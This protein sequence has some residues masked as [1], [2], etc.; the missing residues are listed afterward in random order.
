[1]QPIHSAQA[2]PAKREITQR[3]TPG[4][5]TEPMLQPNGPRRCRC[6]LA[7]LK[8]RRLVAEKLRIPGVLHNARLDAYA[9]V[10]SSLMLFTLGSTTPLFRLT[11]RLRKQASPKG[12]PIPAHY[13]DVQTRLAAFRP[14]CETNILVGASRVA[15][16]EAGEASLASCPIDSGCGA[17]MVLAMHSFFGDAVRMGEEDAGWGGRGGN[18]R[19]KIYALERHKYIRRGHTSRRV[20][21][22]STGCGRRDVSRGDPP[23]PSIL[24]VPPPVRAPVGS[25]ILVTRT[26]ICPGCTTRCV[27]RSWGPHHSRKCYPIRQDVHHNDPPVLSVLHVP[28][29]PPRTPHAAAASAL[30]N[31]VAN[32][33]GHRCPLT[34]RGEHG[35]A[36]SQTT[37]RDTWPIGGGEDGESKSAPPDHFPAQQYDIVALAAAHEPLPTSCTVLGPFHLLV[38]PPTLLQS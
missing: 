25:P 11:R 4:R 23:G 36:Q 19:R 9:S 22:I 31:T 28:T 21:L 33:L 27:S 38:R 16:E 5:S 29:H 35:Y 20:S 37:T 32:E 13:I 15:P 2:T 14:V 8:S 30:S 12:A 3:I 26:S 7:T 34:R 10:P 6:S 17:L 24:Y 18:I 1:M